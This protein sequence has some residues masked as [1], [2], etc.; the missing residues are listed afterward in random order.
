MF[1]GPEMW[2]L[3]TRLPTREQK[4]EIER[5]KEAERQKQ[6]EKEQAQYAEARARGEDAEE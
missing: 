1:E 6:W 4:K 3:H 5:K 2:Y